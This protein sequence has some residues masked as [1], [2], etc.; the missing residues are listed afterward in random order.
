MAWN[1]PGGNN[2]DPWGGG[3][4]RNQGPPDL[5]EVVRKLSDKFGKLLGG[6]RGGDSGGGSGGGGGPQ[7]PFKAGAFGFWIIG[8]VVLGIWLVSGFYIVDE[9]TRG[10]VLRFGAYSETTN[11][12]L[13]YHLP[14]PVETVDIV[15]VSQIRAEEIGYRS[16]P[17]EGRQPAL[18]AVA[19]EA[20]ML[21]R[22]E[23]IVNVQLAVQY[24]VDDPRAYLFNVLQPDST[25]RQVVESAIREVV[26][27]E[28][29]VYVLTEGRADVVQRVRELSQ[30]V[31]DQ[32][33]TGI[34][35]TNV[36]LQDAQP[37]E[38]V[39][40]AFADAIRARE[41]AERV[42]NEARAYQNEII[43]VA[44]GEAQRRLEEA[45][46]HKA[47]IVARATG[48]ASRFSALQAEYSKAPEVTRQRLYL[49]TIESVLAN[50]SKVLLDADNG[51]N[52]LYLPLDRMINRPG[53]AAGQQSPAPMLDGQ[54]VG[55]SDGSSPRLRD[56]SRSREV[57]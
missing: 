5:D 43:P 40:A 28:S 49:E 3:G 44:R 8:G 18:R 27:K 37:P 17:T 47:E 10:V 57:R 52:L 30:T 26:G 55:A 14:Y 1:E 54:T 53:M 41:D 34:I 9:G 33:E 6:K 42:I 50:T 46:A 35:I 29:M 15:D 22:D 24:Q 4:G 20:L 13:R 11:P 25:L 12:G 56:L 45:E 48:E 38:P 19:R 51:N 23:N 36:N 2:R 21:T 39:Q 16:G 32:Y 31:L 7:L